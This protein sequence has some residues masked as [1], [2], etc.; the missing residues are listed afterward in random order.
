MLV[1]N[2]KFKIRHIFFTFSAIFFKSIIKEL[3]P[4]LINTKFVG[5][6]LFNNYLVCFRLFFVWWLLFWML[7]FGLFF[8]T[9]IRSSNDDRLPFS[10]LGL[11]SCFFTWK[12]KNLLKNW[13]LNKISFYDEV[14]VK[15]IRSRTSTLFFLLKNYYF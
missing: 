3:I 15:R 12:F 4:T 10:A 5:N 2:L 14:N 7:S 9:S 11:L 1:V 8:L 6:N 13:N